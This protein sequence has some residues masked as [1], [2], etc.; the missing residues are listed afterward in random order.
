MNTQ[1]TLSVIIP[2]YNRS[3]YVRDCLLALRE[4]G[5]P[6][7]DVLVA[8]DGSTDDTAAVVAATE[9]AARYL[10]QPNSGTPATA[11]NKGFEQS[12]GR[13]VGFLDCDDA[14]LPG[15]PARA[16]ALLDRHPEVDVLFADA[17]MGN[18]NQGY[19]SWIEEA[20]QEE[21]F[22]LPAREPEAGFRVFERTP[23]F[24]RMAVRNPVFIG[25]CV[26]RREA[27]E[28][29]GRF[30]PT[31]CGAADWELWLR[32]ASRFTFAFMSEPLSVYTRHLDN[33]SSNHDR[34]VGEF[35]QSLRNVLAKCTLTEEDRAFIASRLRHHLFNHAYLAYENGRFAEA[36]GR[37]REVVRAGGPRKASL[38][39]LACSLPGGAVRG[40]RRLKQA[41][42]PRP[43]VP[44]VG[45]RTP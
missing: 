21:F 38:Y 2:T 27:F 28:Q 41:L 32:L 12:R 45:G 8:D 37:F 29:I 4:A 7:L 26:L 17:R 5:V 9:P 18:P 22:R 23:F 39:W 19:V 33:M 40:I 16:V 42:T 1:V 43:A 13:Y 30:D 24:R 44:P 31:L 25:A 3:G 20:G 10:W 6:D 11:R 35:C 14:W 15:A 36:R 34:M